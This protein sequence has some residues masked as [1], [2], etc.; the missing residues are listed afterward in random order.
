MT[1]RSAAGSPADAPFGVP[2][3][4]RS[5]SRVLH[6]RLTTGGV[7]VAI[8]G[9]V[10]AVIFGVLALAEEQEQ[11]RQAQIHLARISHLIDAERFVLKGNA[12]GVPLRPADAEFSVALRSELARETAALT[13]LTPVG[14]SIQAASAD[15]SAAV[16]REL[17]LIKQHQLD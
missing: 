4:A 13:K 3:G 16:A 14:K 5:G 9:L 11:Q 12:Y 15:L 7:A 17:E 1:Q 6:Q 10:V 8:L 2:A